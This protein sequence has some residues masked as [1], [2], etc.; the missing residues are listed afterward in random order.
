M[1]L[2]NTDISYIQLILLFWF[3]GCHGE[4]WDVEPL[5]QN[6]TI[7]LKIKRH[8]CEKNAVPDEVDAADKMCSDGEI[9]LHCRDGG[10]RAGS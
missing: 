6:L 9:S 10:S 3:T 8:I 4:N 1:C 5:F 2:R 7:K